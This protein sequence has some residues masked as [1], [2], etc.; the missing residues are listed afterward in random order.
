M[1]PRK[2]PTL[3][4]L[5]ER[6]RQMLERI[7]DTPLAQMDAT[8]YQHYFEELRLLAQEWQAR[9]V[10]SPPIT[11]TTVWRAERN[12]AWVGMFTEEAVTTLVRELLDV[13]VTPHILHTT[14]T[15]DQLNQWRRL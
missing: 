9:A 11:P 12:D 2:N 10:Q 15:D 1:R 8:Y 4:D 3:Q 14:V 7:D 5:R 13:T 6:T